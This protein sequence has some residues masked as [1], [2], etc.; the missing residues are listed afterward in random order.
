MVLAILATQRLYSG[1]FESKRCHQGTSEDVSTAC[2]GQDQRCQEE[3]RCMIMSAR[4]LWTALL[5]RALTIRNY[6]GQDKDH[7]L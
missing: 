7:I 2:R 6:I 3:V 4:L 5:Y 1:R